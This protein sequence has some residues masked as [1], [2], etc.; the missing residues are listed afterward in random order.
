MSKKKK[1]STRRRI[2]ISALITAM[3]FFGITSPVITYF[4]DLL[5][6]PATPAGVSL[7]QGVEKLTVRWDN[8]RQLD[9][10]GYD[11]SLRDQQQR[12]GIE[13]TETSFDLGVSY[14]I[15]F[16]ITAIDPLGQSS[17]IVESEVVALEE[18]QIAKTVNITDSL[19]A[20]TSRAQNF[21]LRAFILSFIVFG[22]TA[23]SF[24]FIFP[25]VKSILLSTYPAAILFPYALIVLPLFGEAGGSVAGVVISFIATIV[26]FFLTYFVMLTTNIL[27]ASMSINLPLEQAAKATQ[28]IFSLISSYVV[29]IVGFS[30][31]I[32]FTSKLALIAPFFILYTFLSIMM[33]KGVKMIN[34]LY[35]TAGICLTIVFGI[36]VLSIWPVDFVYAILTVAVIYYILLSI[37]LE[38][39]NQKLQRY[40]W[41]EY[42]VLI[43]LITLLLFINSFWGI[44]GPLI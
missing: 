34:A 21:L 5:A 35:R 4:S 30:A 23:F 6:T 20:D 39:R 25:N 8:P 37:A 27:Y 19:P 15:V 9:I 1:V 22:L 40:V 3:I 18:G 41:V 33:Q 17:T 36:F 32:S 42:T 43:I 38:L 16:K 29:L 13:E 26:V 12:V 14:P 28:F 31:D 24:Q 10:I 7:V 2:V 44:N 11:I